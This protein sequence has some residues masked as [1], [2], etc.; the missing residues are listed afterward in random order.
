MAICSNWRSSRIKNIWSTTLPTIIVLPGYGVA[1]EIFADCSEPCFHHWL[2]FAKELGVVYFLRSVGYYEKY[3]ARLP[4]MPGWSSIV[5][6]FKTDIVVNIMVKKILWLSICERIEKC[7]WIKWFL[8]MPYYSLISLKYIVLR[9]LA[10][11]K[12]HFPKFLRFTW[13]TH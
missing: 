13:F 4:E 3:S 11:K 2:W 8:C 12:K 10:H 5:D 6:V 1:T 9:S 7:W